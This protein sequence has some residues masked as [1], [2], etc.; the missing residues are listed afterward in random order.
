MSGFLSVL[1]NN[2]I[3][4]VFFHVNKDFIIVQNPQITNAS[5]AILNKSITDSL[6]SSARADNNSFV[7][8]FIF[9][10]PY[11]KNLQ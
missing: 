5:S 9:K 3:F 11:L 2:N 1:K 6:P 10:F 4:I 7:S 8:F